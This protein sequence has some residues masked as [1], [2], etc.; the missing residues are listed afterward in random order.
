MV[1]SDDEVNLTVSLGPADVTLRDL[2]TYSKEAASG[3]L[4]DNGLQL[5]EKQAH[6]DDVPEGQVMK[7]EPSAGTA[8][9]PGS[10]VE[11]TFSLGP[12][13]KPAKTVKE[14]ISIPYEPEHEGDELEVQIAIDDKDHSISDTYDSF[15]IK[16]PTE[17]TIELKIDQGQKGYYQVMV[18]HKVVSYK[19]IEYPK[20]ND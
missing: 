9:K 5:V 18:D 12:E 8:V 14:K 11:V 2:K 1:A 6:S 17:K 19:T 3:Y 4:E 7:Q 16:E 15:K 13:E 20:D 10:N